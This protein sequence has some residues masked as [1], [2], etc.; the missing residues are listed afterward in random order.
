[1]CRISYY[2]YLGG[3]ILMSGIGAALFLT[4]NAADPLAIKSN[5]E[6]NIEDPFPIRRVLLS[7]DKLTKELE[8]V[9]QGVL[10]QMSLNDFEERVRKATEAQ[11]AA[12]EEPRLLE[13][14]YQARL[15]NAGLEDNGL[16]GTARWTIHPGGSNPAILPV[17]GMQLAIRSA[18]WPDNRLAIFSALDAQSPGRLGLLL[19][20]P[21]DRSLEFSWSARAI[22]G[23]A[24]LRF[25]LAVPACP[26]ASLD[27]E[28]PRDWLPFLAQSE[29]L[30][31]GPFPL[32]DSSKQTWHI[33]FGGLSHLELFLRPRGKAQQS[34]PVRTRS[35]S[36]VQEVHPALVFAQTQIEFEAIHGGVTDLVV[37]HDPDWVPNQVSVLNLESWKR[38]ARPDRLL[39]HLREPASGGQLRLIGSSPIRADRPAG[40]VSPGIKLV[41]S[42]AGP[43]RLELRIVPELQ[44]LDWKPGSYRLLKREI[45]TDRLQTLSL[46]SGIAADGSVDT[47]PRCK[48]H[49]AGSEYAIHQDAAWNVTPERSTLTSTVKLEVLHGLVG[50]IPFR[51]PAG[52]ELERV[53]GALRDPTPAWSVQRG[54]DAQVFIDLVRPL[55]AGGELAMV[56][57]LTQR[58]FDPS[59]SPALSIPFPDLIPTGA[60]LLTGDLT[61]RVGPSFH[62]QAPQ[63]APEPFLHGPPAPLANNGRNTWHYSYSGPTP[64]GTLHLHLGSLRL[65]VG[66]ETQVYRV[67][68]R[69]EVTTRLQ[70]KPDVGGQRSITLMSL[71]P[72]G[73]LNWK[74]ISGNNVVSS[75]DPLPLS[76]LRIVGAL[77]GTNAIDSG[78]LVAMPRQ[79]QWW[80]VSFA[81]PLEQPVTLELT[82]TGALPTRPIADVPGLA[83]LVGTAAGLVCIEPDRKQEVPLFQVI[84]ASELHG[85]ATLAIQPGGGIDWQTTGLTP[86]NRSAQY[87]SFQ[88]GQGIIGL[89]LVRGGGKTGSTS[90]ALDGASLA[91]SA[92]RLGQCRC[93]LRFRIRG[94]ETRIL[95]IQFPAGTSIEGVTVDGQILDAV[96]W[97]V[98][99]GDQGVECELRGPA[100]LDWR[101]IDLVYTLPA[102]SGSFL[103]NLESPLPI[104]PVRFPYVRRIWHLGPGLLPIS[105]DGLVRRPGGSEATL[106]LPWSLPHSWLDTLNQ[107]NPAGSGVELPSVRLPNSPSGTPART[108]QQ[109]MLQLAAQST[110]VLDTYAIAELNI[111]PTRVVPITNGA[112]VWDSLGLAAVE[113][114]SGM[115][116]TTPRNLSQ[117]HAEAHDHHRLP[118]S[119]SLALQEAGRSGHDFSGRFRTAADWTEATRLARELEFLPPMISEQTGWTTWESTGPQVPTIQIVYVDSWRMLG[120]II[121]GALVALAILSLGRLGR[122]GVLPLAAWLGLAG[123]FLH[124]LP[125]SLRGIVVGPMFAGLLI[126]AIVIWRA[127]HRRRH[128]DDK[129]E[130]IRP[131]SRKS[132]LAVSSALILLCIIPSHAAAP[133]PVKVF[134]V[135][136]RSEG[137][138]PK[139][140]L[141]PTDLLDRLD[142]AGDR[143]PPL[144]GA[145]VTRVEYTGRFENKSSIEIDARFYIRSFVDSAELVL[146][147]SGA[148]LGKALLGGAPAYP[149]VDGPD[150]YRI[151]LNKRGE[152]HLDL[153]FSVSVKGSGSEREARFGVPE[154]VQNELRFAIPADVEGFQ[155]VNWRGISHIFD[156]GRQLQTYL[157]RSRQV[158]LRWREPGAATTAQ[159]RVQQAAVWDIHPDYSTLL[160]VLDYR[161]SQE[162]VTRL[163]VAVPKGLEVARLEVRPEAAV[164]PSPLP[165][166]IKNWQLTPES[167]PGSFRTLT[168]DLH[169]ALSGA[170]RLVLELVPLR[171]LSSK[172]DL[173]FPYPFDVIE[174]QGR[175]AYRLAGLEIVGEPARNG[176]T[177]LAAQVFLDETWKRINEEKNPAPV[178]RAY[179]TVADQDLY[180]RPLLKPS[181]P[182]SNGVAELVWW[183]DPQRWD[184]RADLRFSASETPLSLVEW[185]ISQAVKIRAVRGLNVERWTRTGSR[186]QVWLRQPAREVHLTWNGSMVGAANPPEMIAVDL[187]G[188]RLD[189]VAFQDTT[190]R[191][192]LPD[193]LMAGVERLE[194]LGRG[195]TP[196][197][198]REIAIQ[199]SRPAD[200]LRVSVRTPQRDALFTFLST[201][202][203]K[204]GSLL[205]RALLHGNLRKD[206]PHYFTIRAGRTQGFAGALEVPKSCRIIDTVTFKDE[207]EWSIELSPR[208]Q[209][210]LSLSLTLQR[211]ITQPTELVLPSLAVSQGGYV[212]PRVEQQFTMVGPQLQVLKAS[213]FREL[214]QLDSSTGTIWKQQ[215]DSGELS[216]LAAPTAL[217]LWRPV[218]IAM[219]DLQ[220]ARQA[221][222]WIYRG[223]FELLHSGPT[224][225]QLDVGA[226]ATIEGIAID[227][228]EASGEATERSKMISLPAAGGYRFVQCIWRRSTP[229]WETPAFWVASQRVPIDRTIWTIDLPR[230]M[231]AT[232]M[233]QSSAALVDL[234]RA[235]TLLEI[236]GETRGYPVSE[237]SLSRT[238]GR[239]L[240]WLRIGE[241]QLAGKSSLGEERG[242]DG[243]TLADRVKLLRDRAQVLRAEHPRGLPREWGFQ[244]LPYADAFQRGIPVRYVLSSNEHALSIQLEELPSDSWR[245]RWMPI[246]MITGAV[247]IFSALLLLFRR[248]TRPEQ[249]TMIGIVG[250]TGFPFPQ[251]M[252]FLTLSLTG[253]LMRVTWIVIWVLRKI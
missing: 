213:R 164:A 49:L 192:R 98:R 113:V 248:S 152:D 236:A 140:V 221:D 126:A 117:W 165:A 191:L 50:H 13:M 133:D 7:G 212:V 56:F 207:R 234:D 238:I 166:W 79:L 28:M 106:R 123:L 83:G 76:P 162:G 206:R 125:L 224:D 226:G 61:I 17:D 5:S 64:P 31:T 112:L 198:P 244:Q 48:F 252:I 155:V 21:S 193:G 69:A 204:E 182:A 177:D 170:V 174:N 200:G 63:A 148:N 43:E 107:E 186:V 197:L 137:Q 118:A 102:Q 150:R 119:I 9:K 103:A 250:A 88:F 104:L 75:I 230:G 161:I 245:T 235:E 190:V 94:A 97:A 51:L 78:I 220:A 72:V 138:E 87:P 115:V 179:R 93:R 228:N 52:W 143:K 160:S 217:H 145:V 122:Y 243:K 58:A 147:L 223:T 158:Y 23:P 44:L 184:V 203:I 199:M 110:I 89:N 210:Q 27:L 15:Q 127:P 2:R 201:V 241:A 171:P 77:G 12:R 95:P 54:P 215:D 11:K 57:H 156:Q 188:M 60:S 151:T 8:R 36:S 242:A 25:D 41:D 246:I 81:R 142:Q 216:V 116:V 4:A 53:T 20:Q 163:R 218:R 68:G 167:A 128:D 183:L 233:D 111:A 194:S 172:P 114:L 146:P 39:I 84:D 91:T 189:N 180:I 211:P 208:E 45:S 108:F 239:A 33:V 169:M 231:T 62:A 247:S 219:A 149:Q 187:P 173:R 22:P 141:V 80:R 19:E 34:S 159:V 101:T 253:L 74:T 144:P 139:A 124:V 129:T 100:G 59:K 37:E 225:F 29:A 70:L 30:L 73:N 132:K 178:A 42:I 85:E 196:E 136:P 120:W 3:I 16:E 67:N 157:G 134:L 251:G 14:H 153:K 26:Q 71:A 24:E 181:A 65:K 209:D 240:A 86:A 55:S 38:D 249:L 92:D 131:G 222:Q 229:S 154:V 46:Q 66:N 202:E 82:V 10:V 176:L 214:N 96:K 205:I 40:W 175:V 130:L 135:A 121:A 232:G 32:P 1:M 47:R 99:T 18:R 227:G 168:V 237:E 6:A 90:F 185:D 109:A 105:S 195:L 35:V